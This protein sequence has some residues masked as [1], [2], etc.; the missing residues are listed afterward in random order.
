MAMSVVMLVSQV[1]AE[2]MW[3]RHYPE[4]AYVLLSP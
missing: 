1:G 2:I 4:G 3:L